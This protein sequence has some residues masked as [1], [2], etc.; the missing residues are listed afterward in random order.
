MTTVILTP[1]ELAELDLQNPATKSEGGFQGLLVAF[2]Q[3][4]DRANR[5]LVL[6]VTDLERIA[7][8]AF[9][10]GHGGWESRLQH[11]FGRSLGGDLG[12]RRH[13]A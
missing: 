13:A 7:R 12:R 9:D 11:I 3:R 8:Y 4:V 10:Y 1:G 6:T 5:R 2:Q